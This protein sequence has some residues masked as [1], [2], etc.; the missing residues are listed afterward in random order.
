MT[1]LTAGKCIT[2][3]EWFSRISKIEDQKVRVKVASIVWWDFFAN[4]PA[5][6]RWPHLDEFIYKYRFLGDP[7]EDDLYRGLRSVGYPVSFANDRKPT[8][9][10]G[11]ASRGRVRA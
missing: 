8:P 1:F 2:P 11:N 3:E 6:Q 4:Q 10:L 7:S 9:A 5:D